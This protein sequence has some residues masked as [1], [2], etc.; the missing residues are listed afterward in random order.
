MSP[1][2]IEWGMGMAQAHSLLRR[3]THSTKLI[4][5]FS[6]PYFPVLKL[7]L[8][9]IH[10]AVVLPRH[11]M[12]RHREAHVRPDIPRRH[13]PK[14]LGFHKRA[15]APAMPL[16]H[17]AVMVPEILPVPLWLRYV[18]CPQAASPRRTPRRRLAP[19]ERDLQEALAPGRCR[20]CNWVGSGTAPDIRARRRP[21]RLCPIAHLWNGRFPVCRAHFPRP[22]SSGESGRPCRR[23]THARS[24][25][26]RTER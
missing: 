25:G 21:R 16:M 5:C 2:S 6:I 10:F 26:P 14:L 19:R 4:F 1:V 3:I 8:V 7:G 17:P 22:P 24:R 11:Q 12:N 20:A 15:A 9:D 18:H 13:R 23:R